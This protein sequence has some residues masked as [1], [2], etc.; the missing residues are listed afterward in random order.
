MWINDIPVWLAEYLAILKAAAS[1]LQKAT[2]VKTKVVKLLSIS[3]T[4]QLLRKIDLQ[5]SKI[6]IPFLD[7]C[8]EVEYKPLLYPD[9][10]IVDLLSVY[11]YFYYELFMMLLLFHK[12]KL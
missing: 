10:E 9:V 1:S 11:S 8:S 4:I 12:T 3:S 6:C 2:K 5:D 7:W